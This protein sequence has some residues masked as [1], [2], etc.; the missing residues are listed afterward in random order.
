MNAIAACSLVALCFGG[1]GM[2][3]AATT[4]ITLRD[5]S[6]PEGARR[7]DEFVSSGVLTLAA[8]FFENW[9]DAKG[10]V[11]VLILLSALV[12]VVAMVGLGVYWK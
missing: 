12:C 5:S 8:R 9:R 10:G 11:K 1:M 3:I 4:I 6:L 7:V 2:F